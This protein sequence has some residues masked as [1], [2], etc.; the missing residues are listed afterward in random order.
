MAFHTGKGEVYESRSRNNS[1]A[2]H[3]AQ[4]KNRI[5][6]EGWELPYGYASVLYQFTNLTGDMLYVKNQANVVIAI[7]NNTRVA[8]THPPHLEVRVGYQFR[9]CDSMAA[10]R[11]LILSMANEGITTTQEVASILAVRHSRITSGSTK[12]AR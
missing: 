8:S 7:K 11:E 9:C 1:C 10:T 4:T 3:G 6:R 2:L 12:T 5:Q